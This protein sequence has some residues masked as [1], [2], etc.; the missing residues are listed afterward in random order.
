MQAEAVHSKYVVLL[1]CLVT[2]YKLRQRGADVPVLYVL[3]VMILSS[4]NC[5]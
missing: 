5:E 1:N 2:S 4:Q 3:L